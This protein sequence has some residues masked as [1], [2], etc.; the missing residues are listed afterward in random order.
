V[1]NSNFPQKWKNAYKLTLVIVFHGL[2][3]RQLDTVL[4]AEVS[5][6]H[7]D[8]MSAQ[9]PVRERIAQKGSDTA[10]PINQ[11]D[12]RTANH[13]VQKRRVHTGSGKAE[14]LSKSAQKKLGR[15][16]KK[17]TVRPHCLRYN[18]SSCLLT[19]YK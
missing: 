1:G 11:H 14:K 5:L 2:G 17:N 16:S 19:L 10:C 9:G 3:N 7:N 12:A 13:Y 18:H 8:V 15:N 4:V 6:H